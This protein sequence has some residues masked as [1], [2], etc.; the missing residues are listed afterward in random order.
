MGQ[1]IRFPPD[2]ASWFTSAWKSA[3]SFDSLVAVHDNSSGPRLV[4][5]VRQRVE[6]PQQLQADLGAVLP[7]S[8]PLPRTLADAATFN[9]AG[10]LR[11]TRS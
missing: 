2:L 1:T 7:G 11:L 9:L 8:W 3:P 6:M 5:A 4:A 10:P